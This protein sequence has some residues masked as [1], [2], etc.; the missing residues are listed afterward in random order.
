GAAQMFRRTVW[1]GATSIP[2]AILV[3]ATSSAILWIAYGRAYT[4]AAPTLALLIWIMPIVLVSGP[5]GIALLATHHQRQL[6]RNNVVGAVVTVAG[7]VAGVAIAGIVGA[8][9]AAVA[10]QGL[11][12][13]LNYR[14]SVALGVAPALDVVVIGQP[15]RRTS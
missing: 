2:L 9:A 12:A 13:V 14:T 10:A 8:A 4:P 1:L 6:L 5:Y 11:V 15:W 7:T 3:T